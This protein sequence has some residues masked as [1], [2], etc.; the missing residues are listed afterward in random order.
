M[1]R[2]VSYASTTTGSMLMIYFIFSPHKNIYKV[3][4]ILKMV[5]MLTC[6]LQVKMKSKTERPILM[7]R[8][9]YYLS[10]SLVLFTYSL[11]DVQVGVNY[12]L[13]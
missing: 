2:K 4:E 6:H 7:Y 13:N 5:N 11:I 9:I 12:T 8:L 3:S 10:T 1:V